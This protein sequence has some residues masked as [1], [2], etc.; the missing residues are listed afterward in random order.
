MAKSC[1]RVK[2]QQAMHSTFCHPILGQRVSSARCTYCTDSCTSHCATRHLYDVALHKTN[3][4]YKQ[5]TQSS[6]G[7]SAAARVCTAMR[8][9]CRQDSL[10]FANRCLFCQLHSSRVTCLQ[11]CC[12]EHRPHSKEPVPWKWFKDDP[13]NPRQG[14]NSMSPSRCLPHLAA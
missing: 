10:I 6:L 7:K 5:G 4:V 8:P 3:T 14:T 1:H 12:K 2:K 11:N 9:A 13:D